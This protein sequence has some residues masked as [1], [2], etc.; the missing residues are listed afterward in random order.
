[1]QWT[2]DQLNHAKVAISTGMSIRTASITFGIPRTTLNQQTN[3]RNITPTMR[4]GSKVPVFN[5][6]QEAE[7]VQH[8]LQLENRFYGINMRDVKE[9]AFELAERNN[10]PHPFNKDKRMAGQDWLNGFL[11]RNPKI[12]FRKPEATS[13]A[14]ARAFNKPSVTKYFDLLKTIMQQTQFEAARIY[15]ADETAVCTVNIAYLTIFKYF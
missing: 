9:L 8:L 10:L 7:L 4:L 15:N 14:R 6:A 5:A 3:A 12:S 13:A 2:A 11:H 1:M